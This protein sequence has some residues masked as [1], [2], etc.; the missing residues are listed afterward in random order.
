MIQSF[1]VIEIFILFLYN[2]I[3][4]SDTM[5]DKVKKLV[6]VFIIGVILLGVTGCGTKSDQK[7]LDALNGAVD[8][9]VATWS[10]E[11]HKDV[12]VRDMQRNL[13]GY[14][15][16]NSSSRAYSSTDGSTEYTTQMIGSSNY[17][18]QKMMVSNSQVNYLLVYDVANKTYY[19]VT[20]EYEKIKIKNQYEYDVPKFVKA[21]AI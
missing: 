12:Y 11:G 5:Q 4:R 16:I 14:T 19:S 6:S 17:S 2:D 21:T 1:F 10:D 7:M 9:L 8:Q 18:D 20:V 3:E 13:D 15:I